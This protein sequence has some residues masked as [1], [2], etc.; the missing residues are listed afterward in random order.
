VPAL[1]SWLIPLWGQFCALL[2]ERGTYHPQRAPGGLG[3]DPRPR[4]Q[5]RRGDGLAS[6]QRRTE[7]RDRAFAEVAA[8]LDL[9]SAV[10]VTTDY[11]ADQG[12]DATRRLL[13]GAGRP[14]A[15]LYDND[16]MAVAGTSVAHEMGV[17]VPGDLSV[18]AG[19]DSVLCEIVHPPLT[20]LSRDIMACGAHAAERLLALL[21]TAT[22][23][24]FEDDMA[25]L[26]TR[27][28]TARPGSRPGQGNPKL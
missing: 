27:G 7:L 13:S 26:I 15:I 6:Q 12:G 4:G 17:D 20:A 10:T 11:T 3:V 1:P 25:R 9:E 21:D 18:V 16:V 24:D 8:W 28:S 22:V 2:P 5:A 19:D 23:A 14:T